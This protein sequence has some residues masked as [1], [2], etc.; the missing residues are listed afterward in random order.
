MYKIIRCGLNYDCVIA[1]SPPDATPFSENAKAFRFTTWRIDKEKTR[2][3]HEITLRDALS[4]FSGI[5]DGIGF[6][7]VPDKL[8]ASLEEMTDY[9]IELRREHDPDDIRAEEE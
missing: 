1:V 3:F 7:H 2:V 5:A 4:Y 6:D 8:F 9:V